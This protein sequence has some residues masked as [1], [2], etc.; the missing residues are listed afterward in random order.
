MV[1]KLKKIEVAKKLAIEKKVLKI[2][3]DLKK[4]DD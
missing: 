1:V 2:K 3:T 4:I